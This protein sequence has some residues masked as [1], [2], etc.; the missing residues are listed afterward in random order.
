MLEVK[1][2]DTVDDS[3]L[4]FAVI[5]SQSNGKW[6]FC[7]HKERDTYEVP[8]GHREFRF[9]FVAHSLELVTIV[10]DCFPGI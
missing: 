3:L 8:G 10:D 7:K 2:Y 5:I 4:K 9:Q 1:F 6:V